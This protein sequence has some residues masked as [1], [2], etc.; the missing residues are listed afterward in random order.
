MMMYRVGRHP[1]ERSK[2]KHSPFCK[3]IHRIMITLKERGHER[4]KDKST[5]KKKT[6]IR[7]YP[8]NIL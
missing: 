6:S 7:L 4:T 3:G 2:L 5:S 8:H 1:K